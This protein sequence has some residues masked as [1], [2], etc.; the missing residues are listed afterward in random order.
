MQ[1]SNW[2]AAFLGD[3]SIIIKITTGLNMETKQNLKSE[4]VS[5]DK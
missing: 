4:T 2:K 1:N 3:T 5:V